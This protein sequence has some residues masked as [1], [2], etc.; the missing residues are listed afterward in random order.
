[1]REITDL[2]GTFDSNWNP[3]QWLG[4]LIG[5]AQS[6]IGVYCRADRTPRVDFDY[7]VDNGV[8][9]DSA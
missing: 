4:V 8:L 6:A 5:Q 9:F 7:R 3:A 2:K 1:M